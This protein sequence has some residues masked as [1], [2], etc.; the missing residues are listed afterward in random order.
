MTQINEEFDSMTNKARSKGAA[1]HVKIVYEK[2]ALVRL[3][4]VRG[5]IYSWGQK[6]YLRFESLGQKFCWGQNSAK[7][8]IEGGNAPPFPWGY[9][10]ASYGHGT[11]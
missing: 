8:F 3:R 10:P 4:K 1:F 5:H 7:F 6:P 9:L 11:G 2:T